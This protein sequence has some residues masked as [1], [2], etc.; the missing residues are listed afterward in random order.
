MNETTNVT[1][2]KNP[3]VEATHKNL[4]AAMSAVMGDIVRLQKTAENR[5][6]KYNYVPIDD[7]KDAIRPLL[8]AHGLALTVS[9]TN[10]VEIKEVPSRNGTTATMFVSYDVRVFHGESDEMRADTITVVLPYV[11][12]QTAGIARSYAVKEWAKATLLL[13]TGEEIDGDNT[14]QE[15]FGTTKEIDPYQQPKAKARAIYDALASDIRTHSQ[16]DQL[17][18][19]WNSQTIAEK[20]RALPPDWKRMA[21]IEFASHSLMIAEDDGARAAF[22]KSYQT[23]L[24]RLSDDELASIDDRVQEAKEAAGNGHPQ[25]ENMATG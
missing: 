21:F 14:Q 24:A 10:P 25:S 13:S 16:I 11:G 17:E 3:Q 23:T 9:E 2:I 22:K 8:V 7:V 12:A 15:R 19:W 4:A 18:N 5:H 20:F 6:G 1:A